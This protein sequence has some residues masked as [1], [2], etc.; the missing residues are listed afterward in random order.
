ME[1]QSDSPL[2]NQERNEVL[3]G[4]DLLTFAQQIIDSTNEQLKN[5]PIDES[6]KYKKV[7]EKIEVTNIN[8]GVVVP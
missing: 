7:L 6:E 8:K 4:F 1:T 3:K 2:E 5:P